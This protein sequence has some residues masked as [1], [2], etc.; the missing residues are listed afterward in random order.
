MIK[1]RILCSIDRA[2]GFG[3]AVMAY[4]TLKDL[5]EKYYVR[6]MCP[7]KT[8]SAVQL[9]EKHCGFKAYNVTQQGLF[10]NNDYIKSLNLIYWDVYNSLRNLPHHAINLMR[11]IAGL[12][13]YTRDNP[14][15][16]PELPIDPN[17]LNKMKLTID[18]LPKPIIV[19]HPLVSFWNKMLSSN[20]YI[21]IL[22]GIS[23]LNG[24]LIQIGTKVSND[25]IY[26]NC[27]NLL[28]KTSLQETLAIIKLADVIFCGDTFIQHAAATLKTPSVVFFCGTATFEFGYPFFN[29]IFHP[30]EVPCQIK[31]G[32]PTRW[33][34]DYEYK[35]PG[36]WST[37]NETGW[38]CPVKLCESIIT[39]D[40]CVSKIEQEL[41]L[42]KENR[43]WSF[44][45]LTLKDYINHD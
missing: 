44:Y 4:S 21:K 34:Y 39:I 32:R 14:R 13:L 41:K 20:K 8:A 1:P 45:D 38:I 9:Y 23:K 30:I 6:V 33:L 15:E 16:L 36:Q 43:D 28:D 31:C 2:M 40:E 42:G 10:Y 18:S 11:E 3:D 26:S 24:T 19:T 22:D 5:S 35:E 12:E 7:D 29:N 17:V 27:V 37:R 25:L